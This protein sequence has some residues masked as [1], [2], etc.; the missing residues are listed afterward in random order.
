MECLGIVRHG[1]EARRVSAWV[2]RES[3]AETAVT[4]AAD[5]AESSGVDIGKQS[6][7]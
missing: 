1:R 4:G 3:S 5:Y 7:R 6:D 2:M